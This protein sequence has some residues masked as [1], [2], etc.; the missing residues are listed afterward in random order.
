MFILEKSSWISNS[1][2]L[3]PE[4]SWSEELVLLISC[5]EEPVLPL[6]S[7]WSEEPVFLLLNRRS[8]ESVVETAFPL[9]SS[10]SEEPVLSC[11]IE[12]VLECEIG[13][14]SATVFCLKLSKSSFTKNIWIHVSFDYVIY[15]KVLRKKT[16]PLTHIL[17]HNQM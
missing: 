11:S 17:N 8:E 16:N 6:L 9:Y 13:G 14:L 5:S 4:L 15:L 3:L 2:I 10:C 1:C 7:S 12:E